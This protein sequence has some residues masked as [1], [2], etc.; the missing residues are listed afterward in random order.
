MAKLIDKDGIL[1]DAIRQFAL[2]IAKQAQAE[3]K[4]D[5]AIVMGEN[6][7]IRRR[8]YD[9]HIEDDEQT[10]RLVPDFDNTVDEYSNSLLIAS[11]G[12]AGN[13]T[14]HKLIHKLRKLTSRR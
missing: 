9:T 10:V 6:E 4:K 1:E 12:F 5:D 2:D 14:M 13:F 3:L 11:T 8:P 7:Q